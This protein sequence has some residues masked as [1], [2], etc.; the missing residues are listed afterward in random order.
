MYDLIVI[1]TGPGGY[2]A[3]ITALRKKLR[4]AVV[5]KG[6]LG[7]NCLNRACIPTKYLRNAAHHIEKL[8][9]LS[10]YGIELSNIKINYEN[11]V[12]NREKTISFLRDSFHNLLK[13]KKVPIYKGTGR[14][15]GKNEVEIT[16]NDGTIERIE[17]KYIIIATGSTPSSVGSLIPNSDDIITTEDFMM[18]ENLPKTLLIVGGGVAGCELGYI[19][20]IFGTK[21]YI[22]EMGD[23]LLPSKNISNEISRYLLKKFNQLGISTFFN[24]TVLNVKKEDKIIVELSSGETISVDKILLTVG[25]KPNSGQIDIIGIEKD[26]RGFI[27][28]NQFLQTNMD[29]IYAIGDVIDSPMLAHVA[30]YEAK[31]ALENIEKGQ[32]V[33]V[34]YSLIPWVVF[35]GYEIAFTGLNETSAKER[36]IEV[37]SGYYPFLYNEKAAD[38]LENEGYVRLY[39]EKNSLKILGADIVGTG[40]GELIHQIMLF[41]K[42]HYTAKDIHNFIYFH[43]SLSEIFGFASYDLAV[44][45]MF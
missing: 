45:K 44:G 32:N 4:I 27:K 12:F 10:G 38:D 2:E 33:S 39:F 35:T 37:V 6:K 22:V 42:E 16:L 43:P 18:L 14:I 17:G 30:S 9:R 8:K 34:D 3:I 28:T 25:R 21:V 15:T 36:G 41:I 19:S 20:S 40:A 1:G 23:R 5:E 31:V 13:S 26:H 11:A 7:G 29:N 24:T